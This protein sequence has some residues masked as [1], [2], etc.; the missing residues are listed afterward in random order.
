MDPSD[1][2]CHI[3]NGT[4]KDYPKYGYF[5][6]K[7]APIIHKKGKLLRYEKNL[8]VSLTSQNLE[9]SL[10]GTGVYFPCGYWLHLIFPR[11]WN[12]TCTIIAVVPDTIQLRWQHH[13]ETSLTGS[14]LETA[15]S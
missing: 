14:F 13:L 6:P 15:L 11:H 4:I 3:P 2:A 9:P 5:Y 10:Q 7:D 1:L 12:G 8:P